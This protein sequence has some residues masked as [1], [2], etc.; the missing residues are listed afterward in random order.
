MACTWPDGSFGVASPRNIE[1]GKSPR[2]HQ[3]VPRLPRPHGCTATTEQEQQDLHTHSGPE[4]RNSGTTKQTNHTKNGVRSSS[5]TA[6]DLA[7]ALVC[8]QPVLLVCFVLLSI[9]VCA[10]G[11]SL[12]CRRTSAMCYWLFAI[13][14]CGGA[15]LHVSWFPLLAQP[16]PAARGLRRRLAG[17][18]P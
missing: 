13:L 4:R 5:I 15:A 1:D 12:W 7:Q 18:S 3:Q 2:R 17:D 8:L 11:A 14:G 6:A 16:S 10:A 9:K